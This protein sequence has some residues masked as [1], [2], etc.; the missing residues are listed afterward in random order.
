[1]RRSFLVALVSAVILT[2]AAT[3]AQATPVAG[4][5]ETSFSFVSP[6]G[7]YIGEGLTR[8]WTAQNT[9]YLASG[10]AALTFN[11]RTN[12]ES[13]DVK[14]VAPAGKKLAKGVY[15]GARHPNA[16]Q[17]DAP[18]LSVSGA[19]RSCGDAWGS[20]TILQFETWDNG[21]IRSLEA[22]FAQRCDS[23]TAP[24]LTGLVRFHVVPLRP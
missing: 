6:P 24:R 18:G 11:V 8:R 3:P 21:G 22:T 23:P 16:A 20:F 4:S 7:E 13:W 19:G 12:D 2:A 14:L 10:T 9:K 17:G 15:R 5:S 1:M